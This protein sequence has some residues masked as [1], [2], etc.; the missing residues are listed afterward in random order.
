M[1]DLFFVSHGQN[2]GL[3]HRVK[4]IDWNNSLQNVLPRE[5]RVVMK[6]FL[7]PE[8]GI[9][10]VDEPN[11]PPNCCLFFLWSQFTECM[12]IVKLLVFCNQG[13]ELHLVVKNFLAAT[14]KDFQLLLIESA[15]FPFFFE[16]TCHNFVLYAPSHYLISRNHF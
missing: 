1:I 11:F 2:C 9:V 14:E 8:F 10:L 16:I 12:A 5:V 4:Q 6:T 13:H 7:L 3:E 15:L